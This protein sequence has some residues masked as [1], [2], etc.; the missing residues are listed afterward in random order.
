VRD[1]VGAMLLVMG[2]RV[3]VPMAEPM[4]KVPWAFG[5]LGSEGARVDKSESWPVVSGGSNSTALAN[6]AGALMEQSW[7]VRM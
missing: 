2:V 6:A 7:P 4:E 3:R 5:G 1:P